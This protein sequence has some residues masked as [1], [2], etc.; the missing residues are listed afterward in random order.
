MGRRFKI[1]LS[2]LLYKYLNNFEKEKDTNHP[3]SCHLMKLWSMH[4][5]ALPAAFTGQKQRDRLPLWG[6][7]VYLLSRKQRIPPLSWQGQIGAS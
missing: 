3:F 6:Q 5:V 4:L 2:H 7:R 1:L